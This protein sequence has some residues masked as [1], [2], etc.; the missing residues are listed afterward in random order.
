MCQQFA[1]KALKASVGSALSSNHQRAL[2]ANASTFATFYPFK[3]IYQ[4]QQPLDTVDELQYKLI[5]QQRY[6]IKTLHVHTQD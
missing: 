3:L 2:Q 6:R 4:Q 1:T 5:I